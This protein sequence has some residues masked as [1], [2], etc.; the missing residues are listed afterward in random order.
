MISFHLDRFKFADSIQL[1]ASRIQATYCDFDKCELI[2]SLLSEAVG[3]MP[4]D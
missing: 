3:C 4:C 1:Q 2:S